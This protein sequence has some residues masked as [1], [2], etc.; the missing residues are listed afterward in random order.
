MKLAIIT[1]DGLSTVL[2]ARSFAS[3]LGRDRSDSLVTISSI[4]GYDPEI[5]SLASEHHVVPMARFVD[6]MRDIL[7][8]ASLYRV[9]RRVR[10]DAVLTYTHKPNI[11][12]LLMAWLARVPVRVAAVRGL[13]SVF[14]RR[15]GLKSGLLYRIVLLLYRLAGQRATCIWFTNQNDQTR[16]VELGI[17]TATRTLVT[18]NAITLSE[19]SSS[20]VSPEKRAQLRQELNIASG[21]VVVI[22][23]GRL[24]R[25]KGVL[26]FME[27]AT[28]VRRRHPNAKFLLV[29]P[30]EPG[31]PDEVPPDEVRQR[32]KAGDF[33]WLGFRRDLRDLYAVIDV[34]VLPSWYQEGGYPRALLEPMAFGKPV[35]AADTESCRSPVEP[36]A[37]G[38]LVR[39]KDG[40]ALAEALCTLLSDHEL[41]QRFGARSKQKILEQFDDL[42]IAQGVAS[43]IR[44]AVDKRA[45]E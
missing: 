31:A 42:N 32:E 20:A 41:R 16:F 12:G 45:A 2:Y 35:I 30:A 22:M 6:P 3:V 10:P 26:Q 19:Y 43:F 7:Y 44:N 29:A 28:L 34:A 21:D 17:A 23:V 4:D 24:I 37:N 39:P 5:G 18:R 8:M 13:G 14:Q 33:Q 38:F 11:Y 15:P 27:A 1:P 36:G 40:P 25:A 9:L